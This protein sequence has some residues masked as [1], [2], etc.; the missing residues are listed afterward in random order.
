MTVAAKVIATKSITA[1]EGVSYGYT[2]KAPR[3]TNLALVAIG[4]ANGVDRLASNRGSLWLRGSRRPIVGRVAMNALVVDMGD[5]Q[6]E[7]EDTAVLFGE[8][9]RGEPSILQRSV[10]LGK[11]PT[12]VAANLGG[13]LPRRAS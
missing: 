12:E 10:S 4:Y 3:A 6:A 8:P 11:N 1:G 5:D 2:F 7:I 13:H 9:S